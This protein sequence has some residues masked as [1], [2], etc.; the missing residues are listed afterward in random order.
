MISNRPW[1][2][3]LELWCDV[4]RASLLA[5]ASAMAYLTLGSLVPSLAAVFAVVSIFEPMADPNAQW[6]AQFR[7]F[8]LTN[9]APEAGAQ[10]VTYL[11]RFLAN[12]DIATIGVSGFLSLVA[13]LVILLRSI[14]YTL[15]EVWMVTDTRSFFK[16]VLLFW[17]FLILGTVTV[18]ISLSA[19]KRLGLF[20]V[21]AIAKVPVWAMQSLSAVATFIFFSTLYKI[22]PNC[23]VPLKAAL[24]GGL[25]AT[26]LLRL[27]SFL[28]AIY[29]SNSSIYK[30]IY[31]ALAA[32]PLFLLWLYIG[33]LVFLFGAIIAWRMQQG[34]LV[35][36][37][38]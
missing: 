19:L 2:I 4:R 38:S 7:E 11:H 31:G 3:A 34:F 1:L 18:T 28:F 27:A 20:N 5:R 8:V 33:W 23:R 16:R 32:V 25:T 10:I 30:S 17:T 13:V 26:L 22:G 15:N 9:L 37:K 12:L 14:E 24:V 36:S 29:V 6:F 35:E 21:S